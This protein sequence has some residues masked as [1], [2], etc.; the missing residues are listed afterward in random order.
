M[1]YNLARRYLVGPWEGMSLK[2]YA[3]EQIWYNGS[4]LR[5]EKGVRTWERVEA[6]E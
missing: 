5:E 6:D 4:I 3:I 1:K 2:N